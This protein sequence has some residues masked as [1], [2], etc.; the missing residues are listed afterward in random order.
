M[1]TVNPNPI[2]QL[3][4]TAQLIAKRLQVVAGAI[5]PTNRITSLNSS[6]LSAGNVIEVAGIP[7][8]VDDVSQYSDYG[9]TES[10]WYVFARIESES[11]INVSA[12]TTVTGAAGYI[13]P[14]GDDHV[15]VAVKF[16]VAAVSQLVTINWG[17]YTETF[18][19]KATDLAIRNLDYR[20]TSYAYDIEPYATWEYALTT[21]TTFDAAK[22]YYTKNG[23]EYTLATVTAGEAVPADT[24]YCHSK[25]TFEGMT[26]NITY[27]CDTPIDCPVIF[28]LPEIEDEEHVI[29][30][31]IRFRHT[32]SYSSTLN[33]PEGVKVA[34]EHTQAETA[35]INMVDLHYT[36]IDGVKLWR[37]MN[38]H[39]SIPTTEATT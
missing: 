21:D 12:E 1:S 23:D 6:T 14:I 3:D 19:F 7:E 27:V 39:A 8:Y 15:D 16:D 13:A 9:I 2:V 35:G 20:V 4:K 30:Y 32:G 33:V 5:D 28:N 34:T 29:W 36:S 10:G 26:N 25:V 11:N 18:I 31:E 37:F 38:T 17:L 24:Y 22:Y